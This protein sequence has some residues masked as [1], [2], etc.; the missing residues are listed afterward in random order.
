MIKNAS[1]WFHKKCFQIELKINEKVNNLDIFYQ[2]K[3]SYQK[4]KVAIT[5]NLIF[6]A[7]LFKTGQLKC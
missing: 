6:D 7:K 1:L 4:S 2:C 5:T 3:W